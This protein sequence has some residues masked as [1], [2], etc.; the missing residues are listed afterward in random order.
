MDF[1]GAN[2]N[3]FLKSAATPFEQSP[4]ACGHFFKA[5][6]FAQYVIRTVIKQ[7]HNGFSAAAGCQH[8][9]RTAQLLA[10]SQCR[11]LLQQFSTHQQVRRL[12]L[13]KVNGFLR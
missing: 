11:T 9:Y 3:A 8:N 5:K 12:L 13:A 7:S 10:K 4:T 1:K 6:G 2:G